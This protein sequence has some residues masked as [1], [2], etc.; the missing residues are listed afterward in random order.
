LGNLE[1]GLQPFPPGLPGPR[2]MG[3]MPL[4]ETSKMPV[5]QRILS[6]CR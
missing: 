2:P 1:L 4:A 3:I 5:L 6:V